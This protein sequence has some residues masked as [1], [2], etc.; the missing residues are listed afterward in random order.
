MVLQIDL[1]TCRA[2]RINITQP[3]V[4]IYALVTPL[5]LLDLVC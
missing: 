5:L 4:I 1:L 3:I 2:S